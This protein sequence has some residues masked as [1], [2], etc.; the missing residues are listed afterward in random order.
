VL[1]A[2]TVAVLTGLA[3]RRLPGFHPVSG[4]PERHPSAPPARRPVG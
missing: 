4:R 3:V 2:A 1:M